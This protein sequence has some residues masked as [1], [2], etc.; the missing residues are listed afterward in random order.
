MKWKLVEIKL[1][2]EDYPPVTKSRMVETA[3]GERE[4]KSWIQSRK[5]SINYGNDGIFEK[6]R[7]QWIL[8][9]W[10]NDDVVMDTV[11]IDLKGEKT[12]KIKYHRS[13]ITGLNVHLSIRARRQGEAREEEKAGGGWNMAAKKCGKT[14]GR[15]MNKQEIKC[16]SQRTSRKSGRQ[17]RWKT[18]TERDTERTEGKEEM[19]GMENNC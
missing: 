5:T 13:I 19:N 15:Q 11:T 7:N 17:D 4:R 9:W 16:D 2:M 1:E 14:E 8:L 10:G 12:T 6:I 3:A 18:S